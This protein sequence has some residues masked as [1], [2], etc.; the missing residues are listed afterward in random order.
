[1]AIPLLVMALAKQLLKKKLIEEAGKQGTGDSN[2]QKVASLMG[3]SKS[4]DTANLKATDEG[5]FLKG[6][7]PVAPANYYKSS[8]AQL[9]P[10]FA[11]KVGNYTSKF[12][13]GNAYA[14]EENR[15]STPMPS[16]NP[17]QSTQYVPGP[18]SKIPSA[19]QDSVNSRQS[20]D[21]TAE[22]IGFGRG[23]IDALTSQARPESFYDARQ[24]RKTAYQSGS[25]IPS[26]IMNK[27]GMDTPAEAASNEALYQQ[28]KNL[29]GMQPVIDPETGAI[30]YFRA[31]GSVFQP[32]ALGE[33]EQIIEQGK[34]D[35]SM[36]RQI[37]ETKGF[38]NQFD[39][40]YSELNKAIPNIGDTGISGLVGR[41]VG[42]VG[43]KMGNFPE[44]TAFLKELEPKANLMA[45]NIEGG[46]I[47]DQDRAIYSKSFANALSA[48]SATNTR[49]MSNSLVDAY[50]KGGNIDNILGILQ[51]SQSDVLQDVVKQVNEQIGNNSA[52]ILQPQRNVTPDPL[53]LR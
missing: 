15:G 10:S 22:A 50:N 29:Q 19:Y 2:W 8:Q 34:V 36:G 17:Q 18:T 41:G 51:S 30:Q 37:Q 24:G 48:P 9:S 43:E 42:K 4:K 35:R 14:E 26:I 3:G 21:S 49:L 28:R 1:M 53:G 40:S 20:S 38:V 11:Q 25:L 52:D 45:R 12:I 5:S 32:P 7:V 31:K 44:T 33:K 47:T 13:N 46:R 16:Y 27:L 39:R 23:F 6:K